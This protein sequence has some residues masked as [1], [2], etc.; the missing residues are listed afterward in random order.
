MNNIPPI[1][2]GAHLAEFLEEYRIS[3]HRLAKEIHIPPRR[4]N[5][6]IHGKRGISADTAFRLG[7][8]FGTTPE[9]WMNLQSRFALE[10]E[11]ERLIR[12]LHQITSIR[13]ISPIAL[14]V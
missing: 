5:E 6:I 9:F 2:P 8:F 4:V 11:R 1:H 14:P 3:E 7:H 12:E 10:S 13:E